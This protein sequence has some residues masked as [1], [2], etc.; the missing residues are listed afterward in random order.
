VAV[1]GISS[2]G[3]LGST[4]SKEHDLL[5]YILVKDFC[6]LTKYSHNTA[7]RHDKTIP[8]IIIHKWDAFNEKIFFSSSS[9][10]VLVALFRLACC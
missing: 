1:F 2:N 6:D 4:T 7:L 3:N 9:S 5:S 10:I 8:S